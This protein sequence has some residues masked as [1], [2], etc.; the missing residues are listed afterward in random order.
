LEASKWGNLNHAEL[1]LKEKK[2]EET[3]AELRE[4]K[5]VN[6]Q[7]LQNI[8]ELCATIRKN[9]TCKIC[10]N[11]YTEPVILPC[12]HSICKSHLNDIDKAVCIFCKQ[13]HKIEETNEIILNESLDK[14]ITSKMYLTVEESEL[15]KNVEKSLEDTFNLS[16]SLKTKE[17]EVEEF[18]FEHFSTLVKSINLQKE[19]LK[20]KIEEI[21]DRMISQTKECQLT[22]EKELK[23]NASENPFSIIKLENNEKEFSLEFNKG[24]LDIEKCE[25]LKNEINEKLQSVKDKIKAIDDTKLKIEKCKMNSCNNLT[26]KTIFGELN[27]AKSNFTLKR[28]FNDKQGEDSEYEFVSKYSRESSFSSL[29][30]FN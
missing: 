28:F 15:K 13:I 3:F 30:Y 22:Y 20:S 19:K 26:D 8:V 2:L 21:A 6:E 9:I 24:L 11:I 27:L 1:K 7:Q 10:S 29:E 18:C 23:F 16:E 5:K 4:V 25:D 14:I 17:N 12:L